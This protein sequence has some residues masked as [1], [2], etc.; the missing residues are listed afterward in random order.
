M[1]GC[2]IAVNE[3]SVFQQLLPV[4]ISPGKHNTPVALSHSIVENQKL[5]QNKTKFKHYLSTNSALQKIIEGK[6]Q[7][8]ERNYTQEY[9]RN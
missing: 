1:G 7:H 5:F 6:V 9:E 3:N 8:K 4:C 2:T